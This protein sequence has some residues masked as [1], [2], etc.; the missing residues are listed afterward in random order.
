MPEL[1]TDR[2]P[3]MA[4]KIWTLMTVVL[5]VVF[6][7]LAFPVFRQAQGFLPAVLY[8]FLGIVVI[9]AV[10]FVRSWIFSRPDFR[11]DG[12]DREARGPGEP[13]S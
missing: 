9:W 8:T 10:Y 2:V 1:R 12:G 5:S 7:V 4:G 11:N 6:A 3:D 13:A